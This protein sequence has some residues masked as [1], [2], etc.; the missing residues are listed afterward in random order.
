VK[1]FGCVFF[2]AA[3]LCLF[4]GQVATQPAASFEVPCGDLRQAIEQFGWDG[5][6]TVTVA[7]RGRLR[8]VRSDGAL[9]YLFMCEEPAPRVMCVTYQTNG[10]VEGDEVILAGNYIPRDTDH[11]QLDP[12]LH[13]PVK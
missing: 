10:S 3:A 5:H 13:H 12:C 11:I 9:V 4:A 6:E 8:A 2:L 7:V 1:L